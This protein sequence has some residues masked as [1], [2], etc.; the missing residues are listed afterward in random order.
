MLSSKSTFSL[1][2]T[3]IKRLFSSL[4]SAIRVV[5]SAYIRLLIFLPSSFIPACA[6]SSLAFHVMYSAYKL[7]KQGGN[8]QRCHTLF[9]ILNQSVVPC[10]VLTAGHCIWILLLKPYWWRHWGSEWLSSHTHRGFIIIFKSQCAEFQSPHSFQCNTLS[11]E[12]TIENTAH[13]L[14]IK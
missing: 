8:M 4:L 5:S 11:Y 9:P 2:F 12:R 14:M 10:L 13:I 3:F 7:N 6:S 1:S